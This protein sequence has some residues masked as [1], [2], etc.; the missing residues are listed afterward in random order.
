MAAI[1]ESCDGTRIVCLNCGDS[2]KLCEC[3]PVAA[4]HHKCAECLG[5]DDDG[6]DDDDDDD[7]KP[8]SEPDFD[9]ED[10]RLKEQ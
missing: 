8:S 7:S 9:E 2:S 3:S 6:D 10:T 4:N 5:R 1:C